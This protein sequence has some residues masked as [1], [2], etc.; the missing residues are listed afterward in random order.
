MDSFFKIKISLTPSPS[1][2]PPSP[3]Y[4]CWIWPSFLAINLKLRKQHWIGERGFFTKNFFSS[5]SQKFCPR[6]QIL[7]FQ[8]FMQRSWKF[9]NRITRG[10]KHSWR[11]KRKQN[12]YS[13]IL[14]T[15]FICFVS[16]LF[17]KKSLVVHWITKLYVWNDNFK[18][19][20]DFFVVVVIVDLR[21]F[22]VRQS[23]LQQNSTFRDSKVL[24]I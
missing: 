20:P 3:L 6:L 12:C 9:M 21:W 18:Y 24:D 13:G 23:R 11:I 8:F 22:C 10:L 14:F 15:L 4:Q 7:I 1:P 19:I 2:P 5:L 16:S 17:T